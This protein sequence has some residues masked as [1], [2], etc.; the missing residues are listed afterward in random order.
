MASAPAGIATGGLHNFPPGIS[1][2]LDDS[3][4]EDNEP[5]NCNFVDPA[6]DEDDD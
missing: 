3:E 2:L 1:M 5:I 4:V 6:C